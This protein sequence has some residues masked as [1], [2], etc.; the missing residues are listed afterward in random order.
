M[1]FHCVHG[2]PTL[3]CFA[4]GIHECVNSELAG[5]NGRKIELDQ[6]S[7]ATTR[8]SMVG[9]GVTSGSSPCA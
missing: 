9:G 3:F 7:G 4:L 5:R 6:T 8:T 1:M 2:S